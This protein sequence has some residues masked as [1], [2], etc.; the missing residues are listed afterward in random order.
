MWEIPHA[1]RTAEEDEQEAARRIAKELTGI[2]VEPGA[3]LLTVKHAVT[4]FAIT[5]VCVEAKR[6]GGD[7]AAGYYQAGKW[8]TQDELTAYPVSAPQRRLMNTL[9]KP[10]RRRLA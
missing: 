4:R 3:K 1:E 7:F 8:V 10:A 2:A 6:K 9:A 5:L